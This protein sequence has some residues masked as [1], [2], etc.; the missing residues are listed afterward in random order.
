MFMFLFFL[1][2]F[3]FFFFLQKAKG[4]EST[5]DAFTQKAALWWSLLL[6]LVGDVEVKSFLRH[7]FQRRR[8]VESW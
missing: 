4:G 5:R 6:L 2:I 8:P 1:K 7:T 3:I